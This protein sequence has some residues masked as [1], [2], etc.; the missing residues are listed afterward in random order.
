VIY[1]RQKIVGWVMVISSAAY[2]AYFW[3]VR[4]MEPGP[5]LAGKDWF[6]LITAI[7]VLFVGVV[8][9]RLAALRERR[10]RP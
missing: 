9:V 7:A 4:V 6:N 8:N 2:L 1:D 10:H 5:V 3:R